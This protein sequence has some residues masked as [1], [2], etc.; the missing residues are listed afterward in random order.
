MAS[1]TAKKLNLVDEKTLLAK[2]TILVILG[3]VVLFIGGIL[4][5]GL[6]LAMEL[7][8]STEQSEVI[9]V[10][11]LAPGASQSKL[12]EIHNPT[13]EP[14]NYRLV[15]VREGEL[16]SCDPTGNSFVANTHWSSGADQRIEPGETEWVAVTVALPLDASNSCQ[17]ISGKLVV[18]QGYLY[19]G[20]KGGEYECLQIPFGRMFNV[21]NGELVGYAC[22]KLG[23]SILRFLGR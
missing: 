11:D 7:G 1:I 14:F 13:R 16:W 3:L 12:L 9:E 22:L 19:G 8:F 17:G 6:L 10:A 20:Q 5:R 15:L 18:R 21:G 23:G 4:T 2:I